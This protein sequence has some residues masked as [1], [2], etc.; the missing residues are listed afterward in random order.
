VA[1]VGVVVP[2]VGCLERHGSILPWC[3]GLRE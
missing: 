3:N 2:G 1:V